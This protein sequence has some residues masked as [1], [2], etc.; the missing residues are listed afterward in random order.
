M[1]SSDFL[2]G[3]AA[4]VTAGARTVTEAVASFV[5]P[6]PLAVSVYVVVEFGYTCRLPL[7]CAVP[8]LGSIRM[9]VAFSTDHRRVEDWPRSIDPGDAVNEAITGLGGAGALSLDVGGGGGGGTAAAFFLHAEASRRKQ[10]PTAS[11]VI[12]RLVIYSPS[13]INRVAR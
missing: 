6:G 7:G 13:L 10:K 5:P 3:A 1:S 11:R 2:V 4:A 8:T 9:L 12:F